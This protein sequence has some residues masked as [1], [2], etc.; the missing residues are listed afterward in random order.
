M[1][2]SRL[3]FAL[4]WAS[5]NHVFTLRL[6]AFS[7]MLSKRDIGGYANVFCIDLCLEITFFRVHRYFISLLCDNFNL[8]NSR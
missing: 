1:Y 4:T 3:F 8:E 7:V 5:K 2:I 6:L